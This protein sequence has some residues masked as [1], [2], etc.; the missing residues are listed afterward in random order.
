MKGVY[1]FRRL[2][3][4]GSRFQIV[5]T[6]TEKARLP[7]FSLVLG[8]K[9]CLETDDLRVQEI[10]EKCSRLTKYNENRES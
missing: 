1:S 10:S 2:I 7:I 4:I 3:I 9:R 5:G 8:T 6:A